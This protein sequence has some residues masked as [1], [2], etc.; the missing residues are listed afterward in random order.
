MNRTALLVPVL[1]L[2]WGFNWIAI[3]IGLAEIPPWTLRTVGFVAGSLAL[4]ALVLATG[5]SL[6]VPRP[7]WW[8]VAATGMASFAA[9]GILTALALR[10][11]STARSSVL[12]ST[13]PIW[14]VIL[15]WIFLGEHVDGRRWLGVGL[16]AAGLLALGW[17]IVQAGELNWGM[18]FAV[19]AGS[20]WAAGAVLQKR[21]PIAA[22]PIVIG[23]WQ[24]A[25]AAVT[26]IAGMLVLEGL[27]TSLPQ[28]PETWAALAYHVVLAQALATCIW[29]TILVKLP[30]GVAALGSL[31]VPGVGVVSAT[32]A[33]GEQPTLGD[34]LGLVLIVG[35][36]ATVMLPGRRAARP[37]T[38]SEPPVA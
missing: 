26:T 38:A 37:A 33:L 14:T 15:A 24:L 20:C 32:L 10:L 25:T 31:M 27:P 4:S 8:R 13:M 3:R 18:P 2:A 28:R 1:G 36:S 35:A 11:G 9:Y 23:T 12:A 17:P 34:W 29:V 7:H 19:L 21:F 6:R 16:G 5:G 30:A 22:P